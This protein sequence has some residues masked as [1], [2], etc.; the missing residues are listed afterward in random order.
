[1]RVDG[2]NDRGVR[3]AL[4]LALLGACTRAERPDPPPSSP[5]EPS[6][7]PAE[8]PRDADDPPSEP[9]EVA[10]SSDGCGSSLCPVLQLEARADLV[11]GTGRIAL[12]ARDQWLE[13]DERDI[14]VDQALSRRIAEAY[15]RPGGFSLHLG[16]DAI[17]GPD[18]FD[19]PAGKRHRHQRWR[20]TPQTI[21]LPGILTDVVALDEGREAWRFADSRSSRL[22]FVDRAG[23]VFVAP[24][25]PSMGPAVPGL[26]DLG[27]EV[28]AEPTVSRIAG[29]GRELIALVVECHVEAP[30]R[31]V[32]YT[33]T[34]QA[35]EV[36]TM[37][38]VRESDFEVEALAV[39]G[40][41]PVVAGRSRD[42]LVVARPGDAATWT[43][44]RGDTRTA[45]VLGLVVD[46]DDL[47]WT[48]TLGADASGHDV[49]EVQRDALAV[50]LPTIEGET[51]RPS[52][53]GFDARMGVVVLASSESGPPWLLATRPSP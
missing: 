34:G 45:I 10:G 28:C 46:G 38:S 9:P 12:L 15:D 26:S 6:S 44:T 53:I 21:T 14:T 24:A 22:A 13:I 23:K 25:L 7:A 27:R 42:R 19:P 2:P 32:R 39:D 3:G 50:V 37:A 5:P 17:V 35:S 48:L 33:S 30:V 36:R 29:A 52:Q 41:G 8:L 40:T 18:P 11:Q 43:I 4:V 1:M 51:L 20:P 47:A 16:H 31:L 49:S